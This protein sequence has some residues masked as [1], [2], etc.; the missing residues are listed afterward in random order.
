MDIALHLNKYPDDNNEAVFI[1]HQ[2]HNTAI[3]CL[4]TGLE[5]LLT[6]GF[7]IMVLFFFLYDCRLDIMI[8]L[9]GR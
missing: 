2:H 9:D 7:G 4:I 3:K 8:C 6:S 1:V 5:L